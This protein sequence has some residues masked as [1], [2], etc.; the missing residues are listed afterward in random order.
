VPRRGGI[1]TVIGTIGAREQTYYHQYGNERHKQVRDDKRL[2]PHEQ[3][4]NYSKW[5]HEHNNDHDPNHD[6]DHR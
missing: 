3:Q 2:T 1:T 6:R 4:N 5:R